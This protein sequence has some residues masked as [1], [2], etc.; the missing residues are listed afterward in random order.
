MAGE[1]PGHEL[2]SQPLESKGV[3]VASEE[4]VP[5]LFSAGADITT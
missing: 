3:G 4:P 1:S 2:N 5:D